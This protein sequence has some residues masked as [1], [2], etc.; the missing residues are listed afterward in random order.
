[1]VLGIFKLVLRLR[2]RHASL[3]ML[4]SETFFFFDKQKSIFKKLEYRF[5]VK[6][7]KFEM[8]TNCSVKRQIN[9]MVQN[10]TYHKEQDFPY[11]FGN[12]LSV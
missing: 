3:K 12:F 1:M 11:F 5:L 9:W 2:D 10:G 8:K 4:H 7:T 6:S